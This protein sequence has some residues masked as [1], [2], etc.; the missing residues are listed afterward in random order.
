MSHPLAFLVDPRERTLIPLLIAW[1]RE[2]Q[3]G[4]RLDD[5]E[6][7]T[8]LVRCISGEIHLSPARLLDRRG[9]PAADGEGPQKDDQ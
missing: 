3:R 6:R 9:H 7:R 4:L 1:L 5:G 8:Q 2:G